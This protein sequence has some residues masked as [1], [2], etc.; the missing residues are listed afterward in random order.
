[1]AEQLLQGPLIK[2][3]G[4]DAVVFLFDVSEESWVAKVVL[5]AGTDERARFAIF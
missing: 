3:V 4:Y 5:A 2:K 1:M